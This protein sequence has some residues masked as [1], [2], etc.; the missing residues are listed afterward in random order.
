M[1]LVAKA[2]IEWDSDPKTLSIPRR[3]YPVD[4][5][6][7]TIKS[8]V[9]EVTDYTRAPISMAA[10]C[11]L[12]AA[13][14][15]TQS[16]V[17][18][19][20]GAIVCPVSLFLLINALSGER[21][22][23]VEKH[24]KSEIVRWSGEQRKKYALNLVR[25][26]SELADY[27]L[28]VSEARKAISGDSDD[29]ESLEEVINH[30]YPSGGVFSSEAG[31]VFGGHSMSS[32]NI[33][34]NLSSLNSL[35]DGDSIEIDRRTSES[36]TVENVRLCQCLAIQPKMFSKFLSKAGDIAEGSGHLARYLYSE[37]ESKIGRRPYVEEPAEWPSLDQY[38]CRLRSLLE[39]PREIDQYGGLSNLK[40]VEIKGVALDAWI[41]AYNSIERSSA[42]GEELFPVQA[43]ASKAAENI[44]RIAAVQR[45]FE[46][47]PSAKITV[48]DI[49]NAK[50]I[51]LWHLSEVCRL[52]KREELLPAQDLE[53]WL[54]SHGGVL[55]I[56][57]LNQSGRRSWRARAVLNEL[58]SELQNL[59]RV[60][61]IDATIYV[62]PKIMNGST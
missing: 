29:I 8:A 11:A 24:I 57:E 40:T 59:N 26:E 20:R 10:M 38:N 56:T 44:A 35:W 25:Y 46:D 41:E 15:T 49:C 7:L 23:T 34:R 14:L 37:P 42:F 1:G 52:K 47:G 16:L 18:V 53:D 39:I 36:F 19:K 27:E 60:Q 33:M 50:E 9:L 48:I 22:T 45:V 28:K 54:V 4:S 6:S 31:Q 51:M 58:L 21:K 55:S 12:G 5:L 17:N 43:T 13:S 32:D 30:E 2:G 3:K 61:E 62:H